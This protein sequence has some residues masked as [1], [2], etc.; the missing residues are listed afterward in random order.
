V[1][2]LT[3]NRRKRV[4]LEQ[5]AYKTRWHSDNMTLSILE[6]FGGGG[7]RCGGT[8]SRARG[9]SRNGP[10]R[11]RN[12]GGLELDSRRGTAITELSATCPAIWSAEEG[13][14]NDK[15]QTVTAHGDRIRSGGWIAKLGSEE[16]FVGVWVGTGA[17]VKAR[18]TRGMTR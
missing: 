3:A 16:R 2:A 12:V 15:K 4:A 13:N 6:S 17:S 7:W 18:C 14:D 5:T 10:L 11:L 8:N 1:A 9:H